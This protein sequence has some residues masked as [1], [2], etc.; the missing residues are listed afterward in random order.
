MESKL[1][2]LLQTQ[3]NIPENLL[4]GKHN[5]DLLTGE[6]FKFSGIELAYLFLE[7][8]KLLGRKIDTDKVLHYE[9]NTIA[10]IV[11]LMEE[12]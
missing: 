1:K 11:K 9:F 2:N 6:V 10:G 12:A 3:F 7:V 8:E 4:D 5:D